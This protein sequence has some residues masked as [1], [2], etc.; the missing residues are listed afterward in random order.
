MHHRLL[1]ARL[2]VAK[3]GVLLQGLAHAGHVAVAKD[4]E[5]AREERLLPAV[6]RHVLNLEELD[7]C[8]GH[9]LSSSQSAPLLE[10]T[11]VPGGMRNREAFSNELLRPTAYD[12]FRQPKQI[13]RESVAML[14]R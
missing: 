10:S 11:V 14:S 4:P 6:A 7:Q 1:V 2:V 9:R 8:L 5:T 12:S 3:V 13:I